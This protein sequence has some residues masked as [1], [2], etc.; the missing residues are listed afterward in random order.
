MSARPRIVV[1]D[2]YEQSLRRLADWSAIDAQADVEVHTGKLRGEVLFGVLA[3][4][5]AVVLMRDRT[6]FREELIARLP[7]LRFV[8]YTGSRNAQL[9]EPALARRGIPVKNTEGG[10]SK[11]STTEITWALILAAVK[12]L[13]AHLAL[14]REGRWRDGKALPG[15]LAGERLGV[16]GLGS[17]GSNVAKVG[18]AFGMEVVAWSPHMT[19]ERAVAGGAVSVS[20]PTLLETSKVVSLHLVPS[21][22]TRSLINGARLSAMREDAILVNTSRSALIDMVALYDALVAGRPG[23]A[24]LDVYDEEPLPGDAPISKLANVVLSPHLGFVCRPVY[25]RFAAGVVRALLDWLQEVR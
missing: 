7:K 25:E 15:I 22:A 19:P 24:A 20:L 16:I 5:D 13:E 1:L 6:P 4:A 2:D 3:N 12:R 9:D 18:R 14:V 11:D 8:M 17:I 23:I 21:E 10:P